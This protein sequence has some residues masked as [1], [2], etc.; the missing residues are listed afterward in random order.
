MAKKHTITPD[1]VRHIAGLANLD[2]TDKELKTYTAQLQDI[3]GYIDILDN[4]DTNNVVPTYQTLDGTV[5]V[6]RQDKVTKSLSQKKAL[7]QANKIH[8]GYFVTSNVFKKNITKTKDYEKT[9]SR[10][11]DE[12][13]A[14]LSKVSDNGSVAHKDLFVTE[15]IV[16]TAGSSVLEGFIPQYSS[17]IVNKMDK[18]GLKTKYKVNQD[19]WGHGGSGENSDYGATSN[20]WNKDYVPGGS[21]SGSAVVVAMGDVEVATGT[22]T[23]GSIRMPASYT[24]VVGIKPT[25]GALSRYGVIAFASSLDCPGFLARTV[26]KV[27]EVF[28]Q[29]VDVDKYDGTSQSAKRSQKDS[30]PKTIGIP[31]EFFE[32]GIDSEV[33]EAVIKATEELKAKGYEIKEI[34]LPHAKLG[35]AAYYIIAPTETSSNLAR[36]DGIRFGKNRSAFGAEAKRRIM[37]G[38]FASS[39]GY[40]DKYYEKAARVRSLIISDFEKAFNPVDAIIAP[41]SPTPPFKIGEKVENPLELYL[42]DVY[43][44]PASLAGL[45]ALA[46]PCGFTKSNLPIGMQIIG[47]RWSEQSL[48]NL[49]EEYQEITDWHDKKPL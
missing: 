12:H 19:A 37:L 49:G 36:Y 33:K 1:E 34:S 46:L 38:A 11:I 45:P 32:E 27:K 5:N 28:N 39:A 42:M 2:L 8:D 40:V 4:I 47:P 35:V 22:D 7:S 21:S 10:N 15:D 14:V 6:F 31:K 23:C 26:S 20:P 30:K 41:V 18:M 29:V 25:Y 43:A 13:N 3:L 9:K 44:A 48:F 17:T 16:T 24:N